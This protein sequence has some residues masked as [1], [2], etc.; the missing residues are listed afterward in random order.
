MRI[1]Q[2]I[3]ARFVTTGM[4]RTFPV[5]VFGFRISFGFRVSSFE[6]TVL[7]LAA[8]R[9]IWE[10]FPGKQNRNPDSIVPSMKTR[11]LPLILLV[12]ATAAGSPA[13]AQAPAV[14]LTIDLARPGR[15]ISPDLFGIFFEDLNYAADGGL[16]AELVQN[17]SFEYAATEQPGWTPMT[18][19]EPVLRDGGRG[20]LKIAD[21][22]P[23]HPNNPHY[24]VVETQQPG[25]G[26][27]L[28]NSGFDGIVVQADEHYDFSL[29]ARQLFTGNRWGAGIRGGRGA[30]RN[31][32]GSGGPRLATPGRHPHA[33]QFGCLRA[34]RGADADERRRGAG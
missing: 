14:T 4:R 6:F 2:R 9:L 16:Y 29:F 8:R 30:R 24:V 11:V 18:A 5:S 33:H 17:R 21:A 13:R 22:V 27:G 32:A 15:A 1:I 20:S 25:A 19:W 31:G 26:V 28:A 3:L 7:A 23:V 10:Y 34:P 12:L